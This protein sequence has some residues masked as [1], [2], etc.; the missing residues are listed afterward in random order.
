P[1]LGHARVGSYRDERSDS[2]PF[3]VVDGSMPITT[4]QAAIDA[5]FGAPDHTYVVGGYMV[6]V[7]DHPISLHE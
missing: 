4:V 2:A 1:Y 6:F 3:V 5:S 7:W